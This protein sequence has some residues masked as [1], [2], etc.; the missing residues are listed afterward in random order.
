MLIGNAKFL[1]KKHFFAKEWGFEIKTLSPH[2]S[3]STGLA[4]KGI[5]ITK[6]IIQ[7]YRKVGEGI[8]LCLL[9]YRNAKVECI[10]E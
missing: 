5:S 7:K 6:K 10:M 9:H 4:G 3:K 2:Y 1:N 8:E